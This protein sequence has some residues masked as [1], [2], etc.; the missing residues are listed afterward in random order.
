M[1]FGY[2]APDFWRFAVIE[3]FHPR[4]RRF[5]NV[6]GITLALALCGCGVKGPLE[7]P[8][9]SATL[10]SSPPSTPPAASPLSLTP[11]ASP[12]SATPVASPPS[13]APAA[14]K[15]KDANKAKQESQPRTADLSSEKAPTLEQS[16]V[17]RVKSQGIL[18]SKTP[19]DWKKDKDRQPKTSKQ[20]GLPTK[21]DDPFI[22]DWLL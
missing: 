22:L 1:L 10:A 4:L 19:A 16:K 21:P 14:S 3:S 18:P 9:P 7:P 6:G 20:P 15:K 2:S 12:S 17:R 11:A 8:P 5:A 13:A